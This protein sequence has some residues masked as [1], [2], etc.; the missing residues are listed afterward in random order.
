MASIRAPIAPTAAA[1]VG[2][3]YPSRMEPRTAVIR[4]SGGARPLLSATNRGPESISPLDAGADLGWYRAR[5]R[6]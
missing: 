6:R 3:A 5:E 2:V 4:N 1:S